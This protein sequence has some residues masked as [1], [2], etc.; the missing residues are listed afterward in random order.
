MLGAQKAQVAVA[1][2]RLKHGVSAPWLS[3]NARIIRNYIK[4]P[5]NA[6]RTVRNVIRKGGV[7]INGTKRTEIALLAVRNTRR[8]I[9]GSK[10]TK[11]RKKNKR[12]KGTELKDLGSS[13][14][15][16]R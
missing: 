1:P 11:C 9:G 5:T 16:N 6:R 15:T 2:E 8:I 14:F 7:R 4:R 10:S 3:T 13:K 12:N